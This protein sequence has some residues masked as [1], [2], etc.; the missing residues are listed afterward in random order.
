MLSLSQ[1]DWG[2]IVGAM[3]IA[4]TYVSVRDAVEM[5]GQFAMSGAFRWLEHQ[6]AE[7]VLPSH[8]WRDALAAPA[9]AMLTQTKDLQPAQLA[10]T[11]WCAPTGEVRRVLCAS[12][13]D[14]QRLADESPEAIPAPLRVPTAFLLLT[15]GLAEN[16][17]KASN[18]VLRNF[19]TVHDA[20]ASGEHSSES[21]WLLS[22]VL[23]S[24]GWW[25][26]WDRCKKLRRAVNGYLT[27]HGSNHRLI[28][29]AKTRDEQ[30]IAR[31]VTGIDSDDTSSEFID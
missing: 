30:K 14:V 10:L 22:P 21:W 24:L 13:E 8:V 27:L 19:F 26:D 6:V 2:R 17:D 9:I 11:A 7:E 29:C 15:I 1:L 4:A 5:A 25:R 20:L 28:E 12:R 3:F 23:P 18:L 31:K 16:S